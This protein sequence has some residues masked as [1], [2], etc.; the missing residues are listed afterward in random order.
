ME[1]WWD[2]AR[3]FKSRQS[4]TG[5]LAI[6]SYSQLARVDRYNFFSNNQLKAKGHF[7]FVFYSI[8]N[9]L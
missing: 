1:E 4:H 9:F 2:A 5:P 6:L 7:H 8:G 3:G